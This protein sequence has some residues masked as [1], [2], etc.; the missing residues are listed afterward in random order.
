MLYGR[1][2]LMAAIVSKS[3]LIRTDGAQSVPRRPSASACSRMNPITLVMCS[4]SGRP[5]SSAPR[6]QVVAGHGAG[7]RLVLH[8]LDHRRRLEV[9]HAL[10][11]PHERRGGDEAGHLVAGVQRLARAAISRGTPRV[12]GVRQ[13]RARHPL[14]IALR[15][16]DL[17]AA[18]RM[19]L[20]VGPALVVEVV[21]QR[22]DAPV[23]FVL[24]EQPRVA[25]HRGFDRQ[26]VLAQALALRV[27]G[28]QRPGRLSRHRHSI[29]PYTS[30]HHLDH[31]ALLPL[32]VELGVEH[33]L[34]RAE[35]ELAAGDRQRSP[36]AP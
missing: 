14:G 4:S 17:D 9:E 12:V 1:R 33:L 23:L 35:I 21:Q 18:K 31:H 8:P 27:L 19:V 5:S 29:A 32:A 15:L 28:H 34:P 13:D 7:E 22:D 36:D 6:A 11:R 26:H 24:A 16:Q 25:A 2:G 3:L 20:L 10:R 30:A